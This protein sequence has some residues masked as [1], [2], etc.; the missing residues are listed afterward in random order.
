MMGALL[1]LG[2]SFAYDRE[3]WWLAVEVPAT[4]LLAFVV[5]GIALIV[6]ITRAVGFRG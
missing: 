5:V 1:V 3:T 2:I 4:H 6:P